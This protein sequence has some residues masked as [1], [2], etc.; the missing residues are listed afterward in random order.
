M[1]ELPAVLVATAM[2]T[3]VFSLLIYYL[4][5]MPIEYALFSGFV[6]T[7]VTIM[8]HEFIH[9]Q[10][11]VEFCNR[12][13]FFTL[14]K[15]AIVVTVFSIVVLTVL[16]YIKQ[17]TGWYTYFIP[18]VASPGGVYVVMKSADRCYDNV[19]IVA[20]LYN[21]VVGILCLFYL[22][23]VTQ[24]PFILNDVSN[25]WTSLVALIAYF[26][27][28]LAFVNALPLRFG[29]VA[30]DGYWAITVDKDDF[31]TKAIA[32]III[33]VSGFLIFFTDWWAIVL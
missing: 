4:I 24:P 25:F 32:A 11:A 8:F 31:M 30:T 9:K 13:A 14:T 33:V 12:K 17:T 6:V 18:I 23:S 28:V 3:A 29:D 15:F 27:L 26:S 2:M 22:F 7:V 5:P 16:I 21:L 1:R 20:P 19:A 10:Y